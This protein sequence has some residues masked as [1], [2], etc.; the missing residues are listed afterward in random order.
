MV[1]LGK[2]ATNNVKTIWR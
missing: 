2:S 1:I